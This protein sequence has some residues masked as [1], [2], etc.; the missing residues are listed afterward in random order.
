MSGGNGNGAAAALA[1]SADR[2]GRKA[3]RT[4]GGR[5]R[6]RRRIDRFFRE[7]GL[8][9][10]AFGLFLIC[11]IGQVLTGARE[12]NDDQ[13]E[14]GQPTVGTAEYLRSG[15]FVEVT[16]ENWESEF[17]QIAAF[18]LL[19]V[20]LRQK[21]SPESKGLTGDEEVDEDPRDA[22]RS[23]QRLAK[24]PWPVRRGGLVLGLYEHS[25]SLALILLFIGS[26]VLHAIGGA[27]EFSEEQ[28]VHGGAA[29][30]TLAYVGT[31]RFWFESFQNWQSE[32]L[33]VGM[34]F[35]L[36]VFLRERGS[37]QSKPVA[38]AHSETE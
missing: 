32:F 22:R 8:S 23:P 5:S 7:N 21:G 33:S 1:R 6:Q 2:T 15:H 13:R 36:T 12:Y 26:F 3:V 14:H 29:V 37:P 11:L 27:A 28:L 35:V 25:L 20:K 31:S 10:A 34:L 17:L 16:F 38:A 24:A 4:S 18:V 30:S 19:T 9:L